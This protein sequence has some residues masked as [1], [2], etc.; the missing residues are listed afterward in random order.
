MTELWNRNNL[1]PVSHRQ[2]R[3]SPKISE[4]TL[5]VS[6]FNQNTV[7]FVE[8]ISTL[9]SDKIANFL[10]SVTQEQLDIKLIKR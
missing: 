1:Q 4:K 6:E 8:R 3:S 5:H 7:R 2:L 9:C 10:K